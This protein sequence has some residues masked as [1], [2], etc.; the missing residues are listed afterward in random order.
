MMW[1]LAWWHWH[2]TSGVCAAA[3]V[4]GSGEQGARQGVHSGVVPAGFPP[5]SGTHRSHTLLGKGL[6]QLASTR[7]CI[8]QAT[9]SRCVKPKKAWIISKGQAKFPY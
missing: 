7:S 8:A 3:T 6:S 2:A 9:A 4:A 1:G 5:Q